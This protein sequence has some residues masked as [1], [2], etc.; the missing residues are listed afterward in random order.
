M[1]VTM[2][3]TVLSSLVSIV[4]EDYVSNRPEELYLYSRDSGVREPRKADYVVMP[5]TVEEVQKIVLLA[6]REKMRGLPCQ[7]WLF[8]LKVVL[9]WI[10]KGWAESSR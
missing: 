7:P 8:P 10:Q 6:N 1:C 9:Y 4:G 5:K 2:K 3:D